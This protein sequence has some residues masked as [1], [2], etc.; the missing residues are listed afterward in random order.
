MLHSLVVNPDC[1][2]FTKHRLN[3]CTYCGDTTS[4]T[5]DHV[6][7]VSWTGFKRN[8]HKGETVKC[9]KECNTLLSNKPFFCITK[10]ADFIANALLKKYKKDL[11]YVFWD[12]DEIKIMSNDFKRTISARNDRKAYIEARIRHAIIVSMDNSSVI[13]VNEQTDDY[14]KNYKILE[15]LH[16]GQSYEATS[17][18]FK[19]DINIL[20]KMFK[21]KKNAKTVNNF[22]YSYQIPFDIDIY[23]LIH[24]N[25]K[26]FNN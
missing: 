4:L 6:I 21:A 17:L 2:E 11:R 19:I 9:C 23:K 22:K 14:V 20:K 18:K 12:D 25:Q 1:D 7:P 5:R 8:Y 10:R 24:K 26:I 16:A 13:I 3:A 15:F